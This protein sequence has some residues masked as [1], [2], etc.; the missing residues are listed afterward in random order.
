MKGLLRKTWYLQKRRT[1]TVGPPSTTLAQHCFNISCLFDMAVESLTATSY[2]VI[3]RHSIIG[4]YYR[5]SYDLSWASDWLRWPV[6]LYKLRYIIRFWRDEM[7]ISTN[8]KPAIYRDWDPQ[9]VTQVV[10]AVI[11][12]HG[13]CMEYSSV[14]H[15]DYIISYRLVFWWNTTT[16]IVSGSVTATWIRR[17][18]IS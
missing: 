16:V 5:T 6:F 9:S 3:Y 7:A 13:I 17:V 18:I 1:N 15:S 8:Q 2:L 14:S 12:R 10:S 4:S 11:S